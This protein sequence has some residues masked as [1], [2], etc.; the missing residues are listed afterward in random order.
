M[1]LLWCR[2]NEVKED[3]REQNQASGSA[4]AS[5]ES[6]DKAELEMWE[7]KQMKHSGLGEQHGLISRNK[8]RE[9][10]VVN[11]TEDI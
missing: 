3:S 6:E 8:K 2:K 10:E 9:N 5:W 1:M 4:K 7:V 11:K